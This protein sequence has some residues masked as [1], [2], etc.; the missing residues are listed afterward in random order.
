MIDLSAD[1]IPGSTCFHV[2]WPKVR[3]DDPDIMVAREEYRWSVSTEDHDYRLTG[4]PWLSLSGRWVGFKDCHRELGAAPLYE[5]VEPL[6]RVDRRFRR[7]ID[8]PCWN[9]S[10][11]RIVKVL[12]LHGN[13]F[14]A[15]FYVH[16]V[17]DRRLVAWW[18]K[19]S[20]ISEE[21]SDT[22]L[23]CPGLGH[24]HVSASFQV[25][26]SLKIIDHAENISLQCLFTN[27]IRP[28]EPH[29]PNSDATNPSPT[30][31]TLKIWRSK[32]KGASTKANHQPRRPRKATK[33]IGSSAGRAT[34]RR[35]TW[36][37]TEDQ[38]NLHSI[39]RIA[40]T[41]P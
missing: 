36:V 18:I 9:R 33:W 39:I 12:D 15:I 13:W 30:L 3:K 10:G 21:M 41:G 32:P 22:S 7:Q 25:K 16:V 40:D 1:T 11:S 37:H 14:R 2:T 31:D 38:W 23:R 4:G 24:L 5:H 34:R 17:Y 35:T 19:L 20:A 29:T 6:V 8:E 28:F 27:F 26:I